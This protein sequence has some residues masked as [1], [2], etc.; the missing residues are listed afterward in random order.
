MIKLLLKEKHKITQEKIHTDN[1]VGTINGL[2]AS[3]IGTGGILQIQSL[4]IPTTTPYE[5]RATGNL[6]Q[7]IKESTQVAS[8]LAFNFLDT[9]TKDKYLS[10]WKDRSE[11]IH[12]HFPDGSTPKDGPSAGGALT[13]AIYSLLSNRK[14]K[15]D[16]AMTGEINFQGHITAIGG[17]E[18][19]L[20]GAKKAGVTLVLYPKENDKDIVKIKE[21][22]PTLLDDNFKAISI[23]TIEEAIKYAII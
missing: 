10:A 1:K 13:V 2:Y 9:E 23:E 22:N 15:N 16:I 11:G 8:T 7:V 20:E 6:Q 19:K 14:I 17:L 12:L 3:S 5:I 18:N 4:W 21:R